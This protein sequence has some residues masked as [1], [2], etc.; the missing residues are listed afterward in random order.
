[1]RKPVG[2]HRACSNAFPV[3]PL[4][5]YRLNSAATHVSSLLDNTPDTLTVEIRLSLDNMASFQASTPR[6]SIVSES[7]SGTILAYL[8]K[9]EHTKKK[10]ETTVAIREEDPHYFKIQPLK[11]VPQEQRPLPSPSL[12]FERP[13][14]GSRLE[15]PSLYQLASN[16]FTP[17]A[18]FSN[19]TDTSFSVM[20]VVHLLL[21]D[22]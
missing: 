11:T 9:P 4:T 21:V 14:V 10:M 18:S 19:L 16:H 8:D 3:V 22:L 15:P 7:G 13:F 1:M 6:D 17:T 12:S 5:Y 20:F 2:S